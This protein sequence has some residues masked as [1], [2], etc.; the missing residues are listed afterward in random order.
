MKNIII[1]YP[2]YT[3]TART[4]KFSS[5]HIY[6]DAAEKSSLKLM[7]I[8]KTIAWS[9]SH[10]LYKISLLFRLNADFIFINGINGQHGQ[11]ADHTDLGM[12]SDKQTKKKTKSTN[13]RKTTISEDKK[14]NG[15]LD[16]LF[17]HKLKI[18]ANKNR[19][20]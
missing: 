3:A 13:N 20:D 9:L 5:N 2:G 15:F 14:W 1:S 17:N 11:Q 18:K 19:N 6:D 16:S 12:A 10:L 4:Y 7:N 8:F